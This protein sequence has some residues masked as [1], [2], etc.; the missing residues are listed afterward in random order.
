VV[1][2]QLIIGGLM[3]IGLITIN[4]PYASWFY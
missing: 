1:A 2:I 3:G 4:E